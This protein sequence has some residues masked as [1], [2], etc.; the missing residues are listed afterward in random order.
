MADLT[1]RRTIMDAKRSAGTR[2]DATGR[3]EWVERALARERRKARSGHWSYSLNRH[4]AL[5]EEFDRLRGARR[6]LAPRRG[7]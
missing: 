5:R 4:L 1:T 2:T 7:R 3:I 6:T